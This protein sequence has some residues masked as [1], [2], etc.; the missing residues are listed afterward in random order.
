MYTT[1]VTTLSSRDKRLLEGT[2]TFFLKNGFTYGFDTISPYIALAGLEPAM[3]TGLIS[4]SQ[5]AYMTLPP[6]C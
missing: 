5:S 3:M 4:K 1:G 6:E 2:L